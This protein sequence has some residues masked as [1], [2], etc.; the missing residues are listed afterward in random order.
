MVFAQPVPQPLAP[1]TILR[2]GKIWTV[3]PKQ[4]EAQALAIRGER[5]VAVGS[6]ADILK[7]AGPG[8]TVLDLHG[9]RVLPGFYD[10]H[11]HLLTGGLHLGRVQLK[12]AADEAEFGR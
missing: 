2:N 9:R 3:N 11:L 8:T 4:P 5:I 10:S 1:E 6:D 7:L 12:D